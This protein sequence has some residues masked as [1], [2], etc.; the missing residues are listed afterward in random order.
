LFRELA[1][2]FQAHFAGYEVDGGPVLSA[3]AALGLYR[4]FDAELADFPDREFR[5]KMEKVRLA[6]GKALTLGDLL[7]QIQSRGDKARE[8]FRFVLPDGSSVF[9]ESLPIKGHVRFAAAPPE[10]RPLPAPR[11]DKDGTTLYTPFALLALGLLD[12]NLLPF[13]LLAS[14]ALLTYLSFAGKGGKSVSS[15]RAARQPEEK[16]PPIAEVITRLLPH[17]T[18]QLSTLGHDFVGTRTQDLSRPGIEVWEIRTLEDMNSLTNVL[19]A[20]DGNQDLTSHKEA[21]ILMST[22]GTYASLQVLA[23]QRKTEN[24]NILVIAP[25]DSFKDGQAD[26]ST[27]LKAAFKDPSLRPFAKAL[28]DKQTRLDL[29]AVTNEWIT[30]QNDPIVVPGE[31]ITLTLSELSFRL[32]LISKV[33]NLVHEADAQNGNG[34]QTLIQELK[35]EEMVKEAA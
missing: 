10:A 5:G 32:H 28:K 8:G 23:E 27:T 9:F 33:L 6:T 19:N 30:S 3:G 16:T 15:R 35:G 7:A 12:I 26:L 2:A 22:P 31:N 34:L 4:Y 18:R 1:V 29:F 25:H 20:F 11:A 14:V 17:E 13:T 24:L 21:V